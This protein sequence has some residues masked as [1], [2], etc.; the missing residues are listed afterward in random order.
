MIYDN[1]LEAALYAVTKSCVLCANIQNSLVAEDTLN[2]S[3]RSP[4]TIADFGSQAVVNLVLRKMYPDD[5]YVCEE[6]SDQ[7][8]KEESTELRKKVHDNVVKIFR[9]VNEDEMLDAID[10]GS[11]DCDFKGRYWTLDP[12][13]G[14]KGFLRGDQYAIALALVVKGEVVLGVLGCPNMFYEE[15]NKGVIY[16]AV[17]KSGSYA[18]SIETGETKKV[19]VDAISSSDK[20]ILCESVESAHTAHGQ[21]AEIAKMLNVSS[22]P[23]RID[24]QCKYAAVAVGDASVYLRLPTRPGYQEKI[25]DHAAG[26]II[27]QEAGGKV[28]DINGKEL[29]FSKAGQLV[30]NSG[31]VATNGLLHDIFIKAIEKTD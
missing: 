25:W 27:V 17:K 10:I 7:L 16:F 24:S 23:Y 26:M 6:D 2:K 11:D 31:V 12:I 3:D 30:D 9:V 18:L 8:R 28:T 5:D 21:S 15:G 13:D 20:A 14:T 4:V 19:N 22:E 1:E 29:N